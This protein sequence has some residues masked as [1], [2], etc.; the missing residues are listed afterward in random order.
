MKK[1]IWRLDYDLHWVTP[2][3]RLCISNMVSQMIPFNPILSK[4]WFFFASVSEETQVMR[5][6]NISQVEMVWVFHFSGE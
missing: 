6:T 1:A 5:K 4:K 2:S 3:T